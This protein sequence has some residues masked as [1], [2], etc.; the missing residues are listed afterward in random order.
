MSTCEQA[1]SVHP[2]ALSHGSLLMRKF[3]FV[4]ENMGFENIIL[5][6]MPASGKTTVGVLFLKGDYRMKIL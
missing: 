2:R 3:Q 4:E 6:G 5:I 1:R